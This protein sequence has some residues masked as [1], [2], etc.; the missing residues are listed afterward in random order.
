MKKKLSKRR[1]ELKHAEVVVA[2]K[3][4]EVKQFVLR[5]QGACLK[6]VLEYES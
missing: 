2:V 3:T 5:M 1:I 6:S 4:V